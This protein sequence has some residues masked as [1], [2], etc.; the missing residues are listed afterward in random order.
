MIKIS[1][2]LKLKLLDEQK[3]NVIKHVEQI[4]SNFAGKIYKIP[5]MSWNEITLDLK[6]NSELFSECEEWC[7]IRS[8]YFKTSYKAY[9]ID[10]GQFE[11]LWPVQCNQKTMVVNFLADDIYPGRKNW[12]DWFVE[13][14]EHAPQ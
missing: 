3:V 7:N 8:T 11:G 13:G 10:I 2:E 9:K 14:V 5:G 12:K 6:D 1:H 4:Q